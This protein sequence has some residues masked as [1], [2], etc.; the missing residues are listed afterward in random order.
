MGT[1]LDKPH[2]VPC[3]SIFSNGTEF[4]LFVDKCCTCVK[5]RNDHCRILNAIYKAM[6][7]EN[8]FPYDDL[9]DWSDGYG[10]KSCKHYTTE[11]SSVARTRKQTKGQIGLFDE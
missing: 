11:K 7:D 8:A 1:V 4:E 10:G 9:L 3:K 2:R 5:Y 6:W